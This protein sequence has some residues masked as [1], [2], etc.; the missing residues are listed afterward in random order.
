MLWMWVESKF[1]P[2]WGWV[3]VVDKSTDHAKPHLIVF[4]HSIKDKERSLCQDLLAIENSDLKVHALH[5]ANELLVG[6]RLSFQKNF[7]KFAQHAETIWK[8][9]LGKEW[10][11]VFIVNKS[12]DHV[13][14]HFD[15]IFTTIA[16]SKKT[17]V[18]LMLKKPVTSS[19]QG[20][21]RENKIFSHTLGNWTWLLSDK[22]PTRFTSIWQAQYFQLY[23]KKTTKNA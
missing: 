23:T 10:W 22:I 13:K 4:Y 9:C 15:L 14:P 2:L 7:C 20:L 1:W 16:M 8:K 19:L 21:P 18:S 11:G 12:T 17:F 5:Y 3:L 6:I